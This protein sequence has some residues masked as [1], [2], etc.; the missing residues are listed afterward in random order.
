MRRFLFDTSV[1]VYALGGEHP[2]RDPCRAV[3]SDGAR[4]RLAAE[5]SIELIHEFAC[6]RLR[7][8]MTRRAAAA[9]ALDI[10]GT[11]RL[12]AVETSDITRALDLW[13]EH[14]RLDMRD[15]IFAAQALNRGIDAIL[16]PDRGFDGIPGLERID[17]ADAGAVASL[18]VP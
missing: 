6:V 4:G 1:F 17:P 16:S 8:G 2:Y 3:M 14:E 5:A 11:S 9:D 7:R 18:T 10:A 15:A 12:L 13:C